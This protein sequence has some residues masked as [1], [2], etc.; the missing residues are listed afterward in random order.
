MGMEPD[1]AKIFN[2]IHFS[3]FLFICNDIRLRLGRYLAL[4]N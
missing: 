3:L 4:L 1:L 2:L